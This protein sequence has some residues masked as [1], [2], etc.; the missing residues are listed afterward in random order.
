MEAARFRQKTVFAF[1]KQAL[2][3]KR[4]PQAKLA[5]GRGFSMWK[6]ASFDQKEIVSDLC[7][8]LRF[9][10][11]QRALFQPGDLGLG[12]PHQAGYLHLSLPL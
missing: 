4:N 1:F 3:F 9:Y 6:T 10:L 12:D 7:P 2:D 5:D 8:K 11:S